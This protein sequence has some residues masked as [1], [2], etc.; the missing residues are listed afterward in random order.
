MGH[1]KRLSR[2]SR[3]EFVVLACFYE[4]ITHIR[5]FDNVVSVENSFGFVSTDL[6]CDISRHTR[7]N[8]ILYRRTAQIMGPET[9]ISSSLFVEDTE[10]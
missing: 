4:R 2:L 5:G 10:P 6:H 8:H 9:G 3:A 1:E 7:A